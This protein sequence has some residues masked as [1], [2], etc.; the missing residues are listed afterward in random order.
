M[1]K[2]LELDDRFPTGEPTLIAVVRWTGG[3]AFVE[4]RA[5]LGGHAK[6]A[7]EA[8]DYIQSVT[9]REGK[10]I[11][12]VNALGA[13]ETYDDNRNGDG[14]PERAY[15]LGE[16]AKCGHPQCNN[17]GKGWLMP[18][19]T[20]VQHYKSF[21]QFGGVYMHHQNK[22]TARSF[23]KVERA[24]WN[25]RMHRVELLLELDNKKNPEV[26]QRIADGEFPA[27]SMGCH[28]KYD[29]CSICG[30]RAPT[31]KDY[32]DHAKFNMRQ[33]LPATGERICVLNPSPRF[34][35]I[36]IVYRPADPT[37]FMLKKVAN[38]VWTRSSAELGEKVAEFEA[39]QSAVRKLSDIQKQLVGD[40][41]GAKKG[42]DLAPEDAT[43]RKYR[44]TVL[45]A[46]VENTES[47]PEELLE[48]MAA[49]TVPEVLSTLAAKNAS[50][51]A[52][53]LAR[54]VLRRAGVKV[55][56]SVIDRF[57]ALQPLVREAVAQ[58]P[59][60]LDK[61]AQSVEVSAAHVRPELA[62]K[63]GA[64]LEKRAAVSDWVRQQVWSPGKSLDGMPLGP[65]Y[66]YNAQ[67]PPKTD[68][69][70]MTDPY[71]GE[72]YRTTR[73]AAMAAQGE[74]VK[75]LLGGTA[76]MSAA[77]TVG[78]GFVP[79]LNKL[80]LGARALASIPLG[81]ASA[82]GLMRAMPTYTNRRYLTDQGPFV[83][84]NTEFVKMNSDLG[85]SPTA[86]LNKLALDYAERL[87]RPAP[88]VALETQLLAKVGQQGAALVAGDLTAKVARLLRDAER[89]GADP[90][91]GPDVSFAGLATRL[92]ALITG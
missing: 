17:D 25:P 33:I 18:D 80:P 51:A 66:R 8:L 76:L 11:V 4:K 43:L 34:F 89:P 22:D 16:L 79:G 48:V 81:Y 92:G 65:G 62:A 71:T 53:E 38:E 63:L 44:E 60:V 12:L 21:E 70:T 58:H 32:C 14:F 88:G 20:L 28:V 78:S 56:A 47:V 30:H 55:A 68:M 15:R 23:G 37:G 52:G 57:V 72:V 90:L 36:S 19:E 91:L 31:R 54:L 27:V 42:P 41:T 84:G 64:W 87:P 50:L 13:Y 9:P 69:L 75:S 29:V 3:R 10:T 45:P 82:K 26:V 7:S 39:K 35:D 46:V 77:Y 85:L 86:A 1:R 49:Y 6:Y 67:E 59:S 61:V 2:I 73:G 24:F 40:M 74:N 5:S 83:A